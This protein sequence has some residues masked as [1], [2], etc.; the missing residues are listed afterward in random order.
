MSVD[1]QGHYDA[2][3]D[4]LGVEATLA[5][6]GGSSGNV[7]AIDKTAGMVVPDARTQI[8]TVRPV[9]RV[10]ARELTAAGVAL[11]DLPE[12]TITL[13]GATWRIKSYRP[14]QAP[15][16]ETEGEIMLILLNEP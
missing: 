16:G 13:N 2:L 8:D 11:S 7:I 15:T 4:I 5:S 1:W 12:G 6:S 3:Y 10:R 14:M 9:A